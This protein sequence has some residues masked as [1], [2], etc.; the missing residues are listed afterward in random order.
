MRAGWVEVRVGWLMVEFDFD[1]TSCCGWSL[2]GVCVFQV[3]AAEVA[4]AAL[5]AV[6]DPAYKGRTTILDPFQIKQKSAGKSLAALL[7]NTK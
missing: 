2:H 4:K 7:K 6:A 3:S 1:L 5:T